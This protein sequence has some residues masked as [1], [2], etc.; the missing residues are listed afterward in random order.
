MKIELKKAIQ[1]YPSDSLL[2]DMLPFLPSDNTIESATTP[3]IQ[4][5]ESTSSVQH[6]L[7]LLSL[8][9][10]TNYLI[11]LKNVIENKSLHQFLESYLTY[12]TKPYLNTED[13]FNSSVSLY[14]LDK[15]VRKGAINYSSY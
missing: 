3:S 14:K 8:L 12:R 4:L 9:L 7:H 1:S 5:T 13:E 15:M 2:S 10:K 11:F 6:H